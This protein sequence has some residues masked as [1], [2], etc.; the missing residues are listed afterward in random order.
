MIDAKPEMIEMMKALATANA[1]TRAPTKHFEEKYTGK[2][3][4]SVDRNDMKNLVY[5]TRWAMNPDWIEVVSSE[6]FF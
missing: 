2:A 4:S 6:T 3:F 5:R 1:A